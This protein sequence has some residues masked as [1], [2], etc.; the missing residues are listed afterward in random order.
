MFHLEIDT[1][2]IHIHRFLVITFKS[3]FAFLDKPCPECIY[4]AISIEWS[5]IT[6]K[7]VFYM[8]I[9]IN[10]KIIKKM[11]I[12]FQTCESIYCIYLIRFQFRIKHI[13]IT[14]D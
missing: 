5:V 7:E 6:S 12:I 9:C 14:E 4:V 8:D 10:R 1:E 13:H 11:Y 3:F 2:L